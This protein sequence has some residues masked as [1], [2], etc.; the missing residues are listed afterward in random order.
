M[1][2]L[3][4]RKRVLGEDHPRTLTSMNNLASTYMDQGHLEQPSPF[5]HMQSQTHLSRTQTRTPLPQP[6]SQLVVGGLREILIWR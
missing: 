4:T 3:K 2:V 1:A 6:G 5:P